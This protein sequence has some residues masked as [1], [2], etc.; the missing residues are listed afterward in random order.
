MIFSTT[1]RRMF[2]HVTMIFDI[3]G[4]LGSSGQYKKI[5]FV[6]LFQKILETFLIFWYLSKIGLTKI[7]NILFLS[8]K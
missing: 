1:S 6:D 5:F 4:V 2:S 3:L 8:V 7:F